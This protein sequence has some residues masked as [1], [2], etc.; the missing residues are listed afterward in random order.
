[1]PIYEYVCE[2][3]NRKFDALRS[4]KEADNPI[5]CK[6]CESLKTHRILST[7]YTHGSQLTH[8]SSGGGCGGCSGGSCSSCRN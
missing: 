2:T 6:K 8:S 3:C 5:P 1:M 4:M 7:C